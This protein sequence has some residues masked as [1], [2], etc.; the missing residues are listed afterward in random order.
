MKFRSSAGAAR[1][2]RT[3]MKSNG[4]PKDRDIAGSKA[5][6]T[7]AAKR[8]LVLVRRTGTPC[9]VMRAGK[10]VDIAKRRRVVA[11]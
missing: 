4:R 11:R 6:L 2:G 10:L 3:R 5:A 9:W 8:A 7:R 1:M